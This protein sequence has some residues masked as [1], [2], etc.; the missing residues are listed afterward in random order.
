[1]WAL[2]L[3]SLHLARPYIAWLVC[4][5]AFGLA[6]HLPKLLASLAFRGDY[7]TTGPLPEIVPFLFAFSSGALLSFICSSLLRTKVLLLALPACLVFGHAFPTAADILLPVSIGC[8]VLALGSLQWAWLV[9]LRLKWDVSYGFY[10]YGWPIQK[11]LL[12]EWSALNPWALFAFA[13]PLTAVVAVLSWLTVERPSL[14]IAQ[15]WLAKQTARDA[16]PL[17]I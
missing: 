4:A 6:G 5:T 13:L 10:L 9:R 8:F 3:G 2:L 1:M 17:S 16:S 12:L 14:Q 15:R 11:L 7:W